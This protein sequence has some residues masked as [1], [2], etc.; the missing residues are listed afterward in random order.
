[1]PLGLLPGMRYEE[2]EA[3]LHP[4][5]RLLMHSDG[6]AEAHAPDREIFGFPRLAELCRAPGDGEALIGRLLAE[7]AAFTGPGWEQEDDITLLTLER[8]GG[9]VAA[10]VLDEFAVPS[11]VGTERDAIARVS[12]TVARLDLLPPDVRQRLETAVGE[13]VMNAAEHGNQHRAEIPVAVR[14]TASADALEVTVT[15]QG[16]DR[17]IAEA[18]EPDLDAKVAGLQTPRGWGLF[19]IRNMVDELHTT[20]DGTRHTVHLVMRRPGRSTGEGVHNDNQ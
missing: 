2:R 17:P 15:D 20:S 19:L 9:P 6:L 5:D 14:V 7:L 1:M 11:K 16:G 8:L 4:G 3:T 12:A 10:E 18:A 13:A